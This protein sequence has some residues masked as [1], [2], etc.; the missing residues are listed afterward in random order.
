MMKL[1]NLVASDYNEYNVHKWRVKTGRTKANN[2]IKTS[3][4]NNKHKINRLPKIPPKKRKLRNSKAVEQSNNFESSLESKFLDKKY[5]ET[6]GG[7]AKKVSK[8]PLKPKITVLQH[9]EPRVTFV[10]SVNNRSHL[11][12][13][14]NFASSY[15]NFSE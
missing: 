13:N 9:S 4:F 15:T 5:E 3:K 8:F 12:S 6:I 10:D 1:N 14:Y 2:S 7:G 11:W